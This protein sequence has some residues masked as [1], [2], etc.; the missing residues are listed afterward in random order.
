MRLSYYIYYRIAPER[1]D[2]AR[3]R[4]A[5]LLDFVARTTGVTGRL[6]T[7]RDEPHLWMEVYEPVQETDGFERVLA[8]GVRELGLT[9]VLAPGAQRSLECFEGPCA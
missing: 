3:E 9:E 1:T 6:L 7:K 4:V 8:R 5:A 2:L